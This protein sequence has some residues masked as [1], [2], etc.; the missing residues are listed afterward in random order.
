V[1]LTR[2]LH[3]DTHG[4]EKQLRCVE[5]WL[6]PLISHITYGGSKGS[7]KSYTGCSLIFGDGFIYPGTHYFI[8]RKKLT[9]LRK[10]TIPSIHEVFDHWGLTQNYYRFDGRDSFYQLYNKSRVYLIEAKWLPSDPIYQRFGSMQMTRGWVEEAGEFEESAVNNLSASV[11]RW[12]NDVYHLAPKLLQTCNPSK[13][14]LY[15]E[16]YQKAKKAALEPWK[17]FIQALPLDNKMLPKGYLENLIRSLNKNEKARLIDGN[18]EYDDDPAILIDYEKALAAFE[19]TFIEPGYKCI[20]ADLARLG[21]DRIVIIE[22]NGFR[23]RVR[24]YKKQGLDETTRLLEAARMRLGCGKEDVLVD[25]DGL[26]GGVVDFYK[27]KGFVNNSSPLASPDA[28][29]DYVDKSGKPI[30][31]NYDNLKSQ[32]SFRMADRINKNGVWLEVEDEQTKE[33]IVQEMEHVKQKELDSDM[34]KGVLPKK[35]VKE[36]LGRSPDFWD[37]IMQREWFELTPKEVWWSFS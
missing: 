6:D 1:E 26:G 33:L 11:G 30:R 22:W 15:R 5:A 24:S 8:A 3:F 4:N 29:P 28:P 19:N 2:Q 32:C 21:G 34:K 18:W 14:Y 7:A 25:E 9:D 10:H 27:C 35:K 17:A 37:A 16:Y 12:K 20:T 31:E 13:N 23:G 36:E